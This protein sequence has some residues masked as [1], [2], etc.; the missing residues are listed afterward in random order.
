MSLGVLSRPEK[1]LNNVLSRPWMSLK[2]AE[3]VLESLILSF[4]DFHPNP[5]DVQDFDVRCFTCSPLFTLRCSLM[6]GRAMF[7][8]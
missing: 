2:P 4:H 1:S 5:L 8:H 6:L 7:R 3:N